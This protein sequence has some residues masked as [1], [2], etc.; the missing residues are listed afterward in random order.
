MKLPA[1][2]LALLLPV[3]VG[4]AGCDFDDCSCWE[5]ACDLLAITAHDAEEGGSITWDDDAMTLVANPRFE[6]V[7]PRAG[8]CIAALEQYGGETSYGDGPPSWSMAVQVRCTSSDGTETLWLEA[9]VT[10]ADLLAEAPSTSTIAHPRPVA[11]GVGPPHGGVGPSRGDYFEIGGILTVEES[12][13]GA[14]PEPGL[15]MSDFRRVIR[16]ELDPTL[17]DR[18]APDLATSLRF[19]VTADDFHY[20]PDQT[21]SV[22]GCG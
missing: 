5:E 12:T 21:C 17:L 1:A 15:V 10:D 4:S 13:G 20:T 16:F 14:A 6:I 22:C 11:G 3:L 7:S 19:T 8:A 18:G 2:V 9:L